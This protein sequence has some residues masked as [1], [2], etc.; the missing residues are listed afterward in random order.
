MS[1]KSDPPA[2]QRRAGRKRA[3]AAT[4]AVSD[5]DTAGLSAPEIRRLVHELRV[6][7]VELETQNE[8]L[9]IAQA[10]LGLSRDRFNDLYDFAPIGYL[11]LDEEATIREANLTLVNLLGVERRRLIGSKLS[12]FIARESQD[13]LYLHLQAVRSGPSTQRCELTLRRADGST[14]AAQLDSISGNGSTIGE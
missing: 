2:P 7:Q 8:E 10:E 6:H 5:P 12:R 13:T 14:F 1:R 4:A 9:R 3:G 11:T